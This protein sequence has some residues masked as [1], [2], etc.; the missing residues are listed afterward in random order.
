[1]E[2]ITSK[3]IAYKGKTMQIEDISGIELTGKELPL[4]GMSLAASGLWPSIRTM[5]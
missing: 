4:P 1:M 3:K 5:K 2:R